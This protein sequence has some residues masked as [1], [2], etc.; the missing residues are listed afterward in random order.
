M[1]PEPKQSWMAAA[2]A[3]NFLMAKPKPSLK[4]GV[5]FHS[6]NLRDKRFV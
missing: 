4:F 5:W 1:E 6:P 3:K 2:R